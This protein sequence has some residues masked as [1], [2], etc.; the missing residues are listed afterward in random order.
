[1]NGKGDD[2]RPMAVTK[3]EYDAN[4]DRTFRTRHETKT[5]PCDVCEGTGTVTDL[6]VCYSCQGQGHVQVNA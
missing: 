6:R 2:A 5:V 1:M 4:Y 3:A